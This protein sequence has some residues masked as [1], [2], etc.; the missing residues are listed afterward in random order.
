M[1]TEY[2][3]A[4]IAL[5]VSMRESGRE[6]EVI[7]SSLERRGFGPNLSKDR[8]RKIVKTHRPDL[9]GSVRNRKAGR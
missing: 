9:L 8:V 3:L 5:I 4:R 6:Y 2:R 7:G 1:T